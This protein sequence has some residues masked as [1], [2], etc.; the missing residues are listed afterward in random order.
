[1][2]RLHL[3]LILPCVLFSFHSVAE[4][5]IVPKTQGDITFVS[6]G[7][8]SDERNA[9]QAVRA[10]YN[11]SV[12]FSLQ[13]TGEYLSEVLVNIS[14][15]KGNTLLETVADGPM[16]LAKLKPGSYIVTVELNGQVA[17]SKAPIFGKRRTSLSFIYPE[18]ETGLISC[19]EH[20]PRNESTSF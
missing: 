18:E 8:G 9:M 12:L 13:G 17:Q 14:D 16:L 2:K 20:N 1:M 5:K 11:L 3:I 6:G 7:V 15:S 4:S 19:P 10:D